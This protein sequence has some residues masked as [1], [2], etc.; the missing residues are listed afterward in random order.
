MKASSQRS[1]LPRGALAS[2][3]LLFTPCQEWWDSQAHNRTRDANGSENPRLH[4]IAWASQRN[5]PPRTE[6]GSSALRGLCRDPQWPSDPHSPQERATAPSSGAR[7]ACARDLRSFFPAPCTAGG[8]SLPH[9][10]NESQ[11]FG[12]S[13]RVLKEGPKETAST[14]FP[15]LRVADQRGRGRPYLRPTEALWGPIPGPPSSLC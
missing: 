4:N 6:L 13:Q 9:K 10:K 3:L 15:G 14:R 8:L 11:N 12:L 2:K 7:G 5:K 1:P